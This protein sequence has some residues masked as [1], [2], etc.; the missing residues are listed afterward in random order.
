M[1]AVVVDTNVLITA[2][3]GEDYQLRCVDRCVDFIEEAKTVIIVLDNGWLILTEYQNN[4]NESGQPGLG[5]AFL[6]WLLQNMWNPERC[7]QVHITPIGDNSFA[8]FPTDPDLAH[9]DR[10]DRKFV[11]VALTSVNDPEIVNA[12]DS[13]WAND[14]LALRRNGVRLRF[15][16]K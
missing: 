2:N 11:A 8:E 5:D 15:L 13:D 10:S 16:C 4:V 14:E 7:E 6:K 9:F 1:A 3:G 12:V